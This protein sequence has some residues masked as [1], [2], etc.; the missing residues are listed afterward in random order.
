MAIITED[1]VQEISTSSG[2]G[3]FSLASAVVGFRRFSAVCAVN[4][5]FYGCIVAVDA[6]GVPTGQWECGNYRYAGTNQIARDTVLSSSSGGTTKV[7]FSAGTKFVFIDFIAYQAKE[8]TPPTYASTRVEWL[9]DSTV[10]GWDGASSSGARVSRPPHQSMQS[11]LPSQPPYV[12]ANEGTNGSSTTK[13]LTG[14]DGRISS[15]WQQFVTTTSS[16]TIYIVGFGINDNGAIT[17]TQFRTNLRTIYNTAANVGK[18]VVFETPNPTV[19]ANLN[20]YAQAMR[21]E[22]AALGAE[23]IDRHEYINSLVA[24]GTSLASMLPDGIH[25]NQAT[26]DLIGRFA[27][28]RFMRLKKLPAPIQN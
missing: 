22:A 11:A 23:V 14:T 27:A 1:R 10:Y 24:Q 19:T 6:A 5:T 9:G 20:S 12:I 2:T 15:T 18:V 3:N 8:V 28:M 17:T 4:D 16:A 26:Y 25:P 7:N 21:D 13:L